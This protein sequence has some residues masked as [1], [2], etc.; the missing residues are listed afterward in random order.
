[1]REIWPYLLPIL[2]LIAGLVLFFSLSTL[3]SSPRVASL[4]TLCAFIVFNFLVAKA[5]GWIKQISST[6]SFQKVWHFIPGFLVGSLPI[7]ASLIGYHFSSG[8]P[9]LKPVGILPLFFTLITVSWEEAWFRGT[10]LEMASKAYS[11]IGAALLFGLIFSLLHLMNPKIDLLQDGLQ[12]WVAGY[13]LSVCYFA[14]QSIWAAI[15]MHFANNMIQALFGFSSEPRT[16]S[17]SITLCLV[18]LAL[19]LVVSRPPSF[20]PRT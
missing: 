2:F 19:T 15:G 8:I 7:G 13:T 9:P 18:A 3:I 11:K 17:F 4:A 20:G 1:M 14:F 10:P 12:L 5:F 6:W 16:W